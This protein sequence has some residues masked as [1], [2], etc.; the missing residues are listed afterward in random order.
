M[1][2]FEVSYVLADGDEVWALPQLGFMQ[3][4]YETMVDALDFASNIENWAGAVECRIYEIDHD[5]GDCK[6]V[7][8]FNCQQGAYMA[9]LFVT[10]R[11]SAE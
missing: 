9:F 3:D 10:G 5:S 4:T 11:V 6:V 2:H 1:T 8:S 7:G